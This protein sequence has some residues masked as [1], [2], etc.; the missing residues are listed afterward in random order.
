MLHR[1]IYASESV[2]ATGTSTLSIAQILGIAEHNNRRDHITSCLMFHG[3]KVLQVIEGARV[4]V[5]RLL[6]R[7]RI[8]PRHRNLCV[9]V[10]TPVPA[11][12]IQQAMVLCDD[13]AS[14]LARAGVP[15]LTALTA[16]DATVLLEQR[17]AA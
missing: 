3:G 13:P 9:I 4:D 11:R 12:A 15:C 2:G 14:M 8:D 16:S 17:A 1:I 10:D 7:L 6:G 5:D